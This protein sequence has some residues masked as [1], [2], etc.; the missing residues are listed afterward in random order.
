[1]ENFYFVSPEIGAGLPVLNKNG[2]IAKQRLIEYLGKLLLKSNYLPLSSPHIGDISLFEKSGHYPYY[3]D[4]MFPLIQDENNKYVLKPMNCPFHI[5]SYKELGLVSY[6]DLPIK[7]Y[8]FGQVYRNEDSGALNGLFRVRSFVQDDG[9][10]FCSKDQISEVVKEC[11]DLV[12]KICCLF[13]LWV[14]VKLSISDGDYK[15]YI[16]SPE[17][18]SESE[19]ILKNCI[20]R[21]FEI[22]NGGAAFYGPKIDFIAKDNKNREWQLGT[23]QLD[24]NLPERF[25]ISYVNEN[26]EKVRPVMIHR[27]LLGSIERFL[28]VLLENEL[29]L[30][31]QPFNCGYIILGDNKEYFNSI[32]NDKDNYP[33][34]IFGPPNIGGAIKQ[35]FNKGI[36]NIFIIG[37]KER[38]NNSISF[39]KKSLS[40]E[41][42]N[43]FING[44]KIPE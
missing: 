26:G 38:I 7:F 27:A 9:H 33:S 13:N 28:G 14:N 41:E 44:F 4:S 23:I 17:I 6:R 42:Y 11:V 3:K 2:A 32:L 10:I 36:N 29:P 1:M 24:F 37:D 40:I 35:L 12:N 30:W 5:L 34:V 21:E 19:Q 25:D 18:W 43:Q 16:G 39:N 8:E 20:V 15:K 31:L 22:D